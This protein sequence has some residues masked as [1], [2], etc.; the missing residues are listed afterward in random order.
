MGS[1][2]K[3]IAKREWGSYFNSP[4]AYIFLMFFLI[5][6][7]LFTF[8]FD[9]FYEANRADLRSFF[10]WHPWIYLVL[11]PA[12]SMRLWAEE[13]RAGTLE[14]ILT[15]PVTPMQVIIGK[16][17][18]AW[19]FLLLALALTF[20]MVITTKYL[21]DPDMGVTFTGYFG[22]FLLAGAYLSVGMFTSALTRNQV[23][24][25]VL[26]LFIG[27]L[28]IILGFQPVT[29]FLIQSGLPVVVVD[30]IA[31]ISFMGH[32]E[33]LQRGIIDMRDI[34]YF[35]CVIGFMLL[36]TKLAIKVLR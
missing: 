34:V 25:F 18:A 17:L 16:F 36:S 14:L 8:L 5:L 1:P 32:Y 9:H 31:G 10:R 24:S 33:S 20:P 21:G 29:N 28:L 30:A 27:F 6:L 26:A 35:V 23:I 7:G 19:M 3:A 4:I 2:I 12:V 15:L 22:S 11:V 13:K